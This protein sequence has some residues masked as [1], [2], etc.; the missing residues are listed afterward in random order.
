V[1]STG[2]VEEPISSELVLVD[3]ALAPRAR[4]A[5]PEPPWLLPVLAD[6]RESAHAEPSPA[7]PAQATPEQP[8]PRRAPRAATAVCVVLA[9][10][11]LAVAALAFFPLSSRPTLAT[12]SPE[13]AAPARPVRPPVVGRP[14][15]AATRPTRH[16]A[17]PSTARKK[18]SAEP[19]KSSDARAKARRPPARVGMTPRTLTRA[20][21]TLSWR[22]DPAA[23]FYELYVQRGAET[24]YETRTARPSVVL[25]A[26]L[27]L[28]PGRYQVLV[29]PAISNDAGI[30]LGAVILRRTLRV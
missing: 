24:I 25:P 6:L 22:R 10:G 11:G 27:A 1:G 4:A 9:L 30:T 2:V 17:K 7:R 3:Q 19:S 12:S 23:A 18:Q 28:R 8:A 15:R 5:L 20:Q 26:G 13:D 29:R 16:A 21:R 14:K